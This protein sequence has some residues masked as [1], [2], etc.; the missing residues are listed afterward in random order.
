MS[1]IETNW[2]F[3]SLEKETPTEKANTKVKKKKKIQSH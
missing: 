2:I 3:K 1:L